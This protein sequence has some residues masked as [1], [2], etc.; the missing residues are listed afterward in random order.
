MKP[1]R[2]KQLIL[3]VVA[4]VILVIGIGSSTTADAQGRVI[5]RP[6]PVIIYRH[7][8]PFWYRHYDPFW[9]PYWGPTYTYVDPIAYQREQGY[10]EGRDEGKD[11]AKK[12]RP[13]NPTGHKDYLKSNSITYREAFVQGYNERYKEEI[14]KLQE[15][16]REKHGD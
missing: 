3:G 6:R 10:R 8:N 4:A 11:D 14:A 9:S 1:N 13:A 12:G 15:K 7:Y 5:R 16:A 2:V